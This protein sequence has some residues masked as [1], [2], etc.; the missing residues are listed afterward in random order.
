[1][2]WAN[3]LIEKCKAEAKERQAIEEEYNEKWREFE[4][5]ELS[6]APEPP[7]ALKEAP[8][9]RVIVATAVTPGRGEAYGWR[10]YALLLGPYSSSDVFYY[11][12]LNDA[13][14]K[15]AKRRFKEAGL[16]FEDIMAWTAFD[17]AA[18]RNWLTPPR[19]PRC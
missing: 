15:Y 10:R 11:Y 8:Q 3:E 5:G 2:N 12:P 1:M 14:R 6:V 13:L 16:Q 9:G 18:W 7:D 19:R 4:N 17:V